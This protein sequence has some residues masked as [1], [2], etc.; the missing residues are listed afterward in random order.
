[1]RM[2]YVTV[3]VNGQLDAWTGKNPDKYPQSINEAKKRANFLREC[4]FKTAYPII[5]IEIKETD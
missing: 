1:M 2:K 4:G 3:V 5:V